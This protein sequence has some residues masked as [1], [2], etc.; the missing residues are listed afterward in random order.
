MPPELMA[1]AREQNVFVDMPPSPASGRGRKEEGMIAPASRKLGK[2][3]IRQKLGRGGMA[4]VYLAQDT[5][6][7]G[8]P[9]R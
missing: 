4:D 1:A 7:S 6:L 5:E 8:R 9:S 2:Y 3:E